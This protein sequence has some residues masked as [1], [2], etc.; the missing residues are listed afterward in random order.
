MFGSLIFLPA[1]LVAQAS[2]AAPTPTPAAQKPTVKTST[3]A[4]H[5]AAAAKPKSPVAPRPM[6]D[7]EKTIYALGLTISRSLGQFDL[8]PR[9][10]DI[11]K[12]ALTD[13]AAGKPAV[14]LATWGPKIDQLAHD[15]AAVVAAREKAASQAYLTKA[16]AQPGAAKTDSGLIYREITPGTGPSPSASDTVTV[17]Y[18]GTLVDGKEFDSS[19]ARNQPA[20]FPLTRV[21]RCW[22]EGLQK[23]K[24]G[25]KSVLVC[26]SDIAYGDNGHPPDI[27]G[28][29]TLIFEIELLKIGGA[30]Q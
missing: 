10:L 13:A 27:P 1:V 16:A 30:G 26:P 17:N 14:D 6:T 25:G 28:G 9:E 5:R 29:A 4:P 7:Q 19:Y 20:T 8:S 11:I 15:R 22:T 2:Q 24:V 12:R 3:A 21:I 23:M 18:R